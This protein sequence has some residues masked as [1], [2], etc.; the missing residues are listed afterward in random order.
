MKKHVFFLIFCVAKLNS[1]SLQW[2]AS[3]PYTSHFSGDNKIVS[4]NSGNVYVLSYWMNQG[5]YFMKYNDKGVKQWE[6]AWQGGASIK[7]LA[8]DNSGF[9]YL[10]IGVWNNGIAMEN[11][12]YESGDLLLKYSS[13]GN[14]RWIKRPN[15]GYTLWLPKKFR[16]DGL[17]MTTGNYDVT[18][19]LNLP[20]APNIAS[21]IYVGQADTSLSMLWAVNKEGARSTPATKDSSFY[22]NDYFPLQLTL[23]QGTNTFQPMKDYSYLAKY[24]N[25]GKRIYAINING[26]G[27][28]G[29][30]G[31]FY[32]FEW[33][34]RSIEGS[35][36]MLDALG[37]KAWKS[38]KISAG[39]W[40]KTTMVSDD[41][42]NIFFAG[43]FKDFFEIEGKKTEQPGYHVFFAKWNK[44]GKFVSLFTSSGSGFASVRD[45]TI[46]GNV[47]YITGELNG[48][49]EFGGHTITE[50]NGGIFT[51]KLLNDNNMVSIN[52]N[53]NSIIDLK[54]FPNPSASEIKLSYRNLSV[55][56]V[57]ISIFDLTG[58][59]VFYKNFGSIEQVNE[60]LELN[61]FSTGAYTLSLQHG[62]AV[63][64]RKFIVQ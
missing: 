49:I 55:E 19:K 38:S 50:S 59:K 13:D 9:I 2:L 51:A 23:G 56:N 7:S 26:G 11:K 47:I 12:E 20:L 3:E 33:L 14:I 16:A 46:E 27:T 6:K 52:E 60:K 44:S 40:Y 25:S 32:C 45:I 10:V 54:V 64:T 31:S 57:S 48:T 58:R 34:P 61:A 35:L 17:M 39:A 37:H 1:Q 43:G 24:N 41:E 15:E 4:D 62:S 18:N 28:P 36:F 63:E 53:K 22:V 29:L 21:S 5:L 30:D 42:G 8:V